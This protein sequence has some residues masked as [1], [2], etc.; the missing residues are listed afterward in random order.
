MAKIVLFD[1]DILY[2][3]CLSLQLTNNHQVVGE[4]G[5]FSKVVFMVQTA[6]PDVALL[7]LSSTNII[8]CI[9]Q[10]KE[11][12]ETKVVVYSVPVNP[13]LISSVLRSGAAGILLRTES[14]FEELMNAIVLVMTNRTY[15]G[16]GV[17]D[18]LS[19]CFQNSI[20][21][22]D[23]SS[24]FSLLTSREREV[25][26]LIAEGRSTRNIAEHL[27]VSGKTVESHR[28]RIMRKLSITSVA[29]ITKYALQEGLT[30]LNITPPKLGGGLQHG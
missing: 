25:V 2:R 24:C 11:S 26:Q 14:N 13:H 4:T 20:D 5:D 15:F 12:M 16:R 1:D 21:M 18:I 10:I 22:N 19:S 3:Q 9:S 8:D 17:S 28:Q 29:E 23:L 27:N 6:S 7:K 30:S